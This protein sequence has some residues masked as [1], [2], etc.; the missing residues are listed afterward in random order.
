M[1][2]VALYDALDDLDGARPTNRPPQQIQHDRHDGDVDPDEVPAGT[3]PRAPER[4]EFCEQPPK[5]IV[6]DRPVYTRVHLLRIVVCER[7]AGNS[8]ASLK[9]L[10]RP[11][12]IA[13]YCAQS[14]SLRRLL[15][16]SRR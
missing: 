9:Q 5:N 14:G 2:D 16:G 10:M 6:H 8:H 7:V 15:A 4:I 11:V 13:Q 1:L 12:I 3:H